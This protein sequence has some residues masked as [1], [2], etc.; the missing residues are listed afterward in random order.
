MRPLWP[1]CRWHADFTLD[2]NFQ[3]NFWGCLS[4]NHPELMQPFFGT[5]TADWFWAISRM[6]ASANWQVCSL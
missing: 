2:Y 6:R 3:A 1:L 5:L 4:S